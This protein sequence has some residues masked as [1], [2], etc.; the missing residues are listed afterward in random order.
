MRPNRYA[1]E[2][3]SSAIH[4]MA[5]SNKSLKDRIAMGYVNELCHIGGEDRTKDKRV[6]QTLDQLDK[7]FR[8]KDSE[9]KILDAYSSVRHKR[10]TTVQNMAELIFDTF[11]YL[12]NQS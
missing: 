12:K 6:S 5:T 7:F 11:I 10:H 4:Y 8:R 2:K 3:F 1:Y 9:G